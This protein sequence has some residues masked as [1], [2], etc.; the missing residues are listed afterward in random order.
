MYLKFLSN[1]ANSEASITVTTYSM[2]NIYWGDGTHTYNVS[3]NNK[4]VEHT[5]DDPGEYDIVI[6][7]VIEDIES[8]STNAIVVW[9]KLK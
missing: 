5:Y 3:G 8:F 2:L 4:T 7:G 9:D 6:T 1:T